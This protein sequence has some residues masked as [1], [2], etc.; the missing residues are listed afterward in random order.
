MRQVSGSGYR[1]QASSYPVFERAQRYQTS[2]PQGQSCAAF[3]TQAG[4]CAGYANVLKVCCIPVNRAICTPRARQSAREWPTIITRISKCAMKVF[5]TGG[6]GGIGKAL[7]E[8]YLR[9]GHEVGICG[10]DQAASAAAFPAP[11]PQLSFVE[12]D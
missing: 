6:T 11:P 4:R 9:A 8:H 12:L 7:T 5:I 10:G 3:S 2:H 1:C